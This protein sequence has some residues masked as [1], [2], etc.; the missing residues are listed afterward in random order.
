LA[1]EPRVHQTVIGD[2][3]LDVLLDEGVEHGVG[4]LVADIVRMTFGHRLAGE[5]KIRLHAE[6]PHVERR[7][8]APYRRVLA[9]S[10]GKV[11]M[12]ARWAKRPKEDGISW[13]GNIVNVAIEGGKSED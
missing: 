10:P 2:A 12:R 8:P 4:N 5:Q 6:L 9:A 13:A 1:A 11:K 7:I 3:E